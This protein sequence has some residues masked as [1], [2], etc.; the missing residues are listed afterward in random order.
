MIAL[1]DYQNDAIAELRARTLLGVTS[2]VLVMM[3]GAGKTV[4]AASIM[5]GAMR[6]GSRLLFLAHRK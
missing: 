4:V 5:E 3:T 1:R 6:Q 2:I